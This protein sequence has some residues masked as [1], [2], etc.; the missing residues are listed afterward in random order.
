MPS[1]WA[2][3]I[4]STW[5]WLAAEVQGV[6]VVSTRTSTKRQMNLSPTFLIIAPGSSPASSRIWK[7]LQMPITRPPAAACFST[8]FMTGENF[9]TAPVR[10]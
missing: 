7:P 2:M 4:F 3:G 1:L 9:A 5:P 10:R 6:L 8:A